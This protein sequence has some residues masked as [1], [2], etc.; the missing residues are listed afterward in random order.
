MRYLA[1]ERPLRPLSFRPARPVRLIWPNHQYQLD[2]QLEVNKIAPLDKLA[3]ECL[4][5]TT[6]GQSRVQF[7]GRRYTL[8][9]YWQYL[10]KSF[11]QYAT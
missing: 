4:R 1:S 5:G 3:K 7:M 6:M 9:D 8:T 11:E 2:S 10:T